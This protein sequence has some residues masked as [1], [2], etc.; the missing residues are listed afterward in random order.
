MTTGKDNHVLMVTAGY[1]YCVERM[2]REEDQLSGLARV[3]SN[4]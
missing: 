4:R 3:G 2:E 1:Q